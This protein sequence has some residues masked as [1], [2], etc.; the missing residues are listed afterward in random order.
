MLDPQSQQIHTIAVEKAAKYLVAEAELLGA[1]I[2]V[3]RARLFEKFSEP[4]LT[5]Y[6]V[7]YLG[8]SEDVAAQFVRVARKSQQ[9]PELE[10]AVAQGL[11]I[12][13]AK[14][15]ASVID[16]Q[17]TSEW[18]LKAQTLSKEKL[19][20]EVAAAK[21]SAPRPE[22]A[23]PTG[24]NRVRIELEVTSEEAE[25]IKRARELMSQKNRRP[26][27]MGETVVQALK[28]WV[29]R[30]DPV[31]RA[32]RAV[33]RQQK[34]RVKP[35]GQRSWDRSA[36]PAAIRHQVHRRDRGACCQS[37]PDGSRCGLRQWTEIHH[38]QPRA[39]GGADTIENLITLC[40]AH[41]RQWHA[42]SKS[43]FEMRC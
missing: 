8:L 16:A 19:E 4:Y 30:V 7:K 15:I 10:R 25:L 42:R 29:D 21:P 37:M 20:R 17:N 38:L 23:R 27:Q 11:Q 32:E 39:H 12:S 2:D 40:S 43:D 24:A 9:V 22:K 33:S 18:I 28:E 31:R 5:P 14:T 41:H 26:V 35:V 6:C 13:K 36:I 3:D 34:T 1:I